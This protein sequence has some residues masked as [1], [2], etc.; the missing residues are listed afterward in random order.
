M[1]NLN[2]PG[3]HLREIKKGELGQF[4]KIEEEFEEFLDAIEQKNPIMALVELSD[5][6]GA[7]EHYCQTNNFLLEKFKGHVIEKSKIVDIM[8]HLM[9]KCNTW[10]DKDR[11]YLLSQLM[12]CITNYCYFHNIYPEDLK[13]MNDVTQRAFKNGRR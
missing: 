4:S 6:M 12:D 9:N 11:Q 1:S 5:M 13:T 7:I 10:T 3:Y 2:K 8:V